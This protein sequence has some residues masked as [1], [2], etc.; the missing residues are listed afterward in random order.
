MLDWIY[1]FYLL[2]VHC[3]EQF[4]DYG[5]CSLHRMIS[6]PPCHLY[7]TKLLN[8]FSNGYSDLNFDLF[9]FIL[10]YYTKRISMQIYK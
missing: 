1:L 9:Y 8:G 10:E 6:Y 7:I 5:V 2:D 3:F 4:E